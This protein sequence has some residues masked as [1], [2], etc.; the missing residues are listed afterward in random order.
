MTGSSLMLLAL[1]PMVPLT[2]QNHG[3]SG[4]KPGPVR[5]SARSPSLRPDPTSLEVTGSHGTTRRITLLRRTGDG[6]LVPLV[7]LAQA[8]GGTVARDSGWVV[9]DTPAGRFRFLPGTP[10]VDT[11][12]DVRGLPAPSMARGDTVFIP[13]AFVADVLADPDRQS[14]HWSP[15][16]AL[17]AAGRAPAPLVNRPARTTAGA[18]ARTR[19]P[20]GLRPGHHVTIDPGHG[21]TDPG[22]PGIFFPQG[23]QEKDVTLAIGLQVR[24]V[25]QKR[26]VT[27]TMTRSTDTLISLFDR[28]PDY[29]R[30]NCDLFVS[31]HV[32]SLEKRPGYTKMRGFETYFLSEA[33]TADAARVAKMENSAL[34]YDL[35]SKQTAPGGLNFI[36]KDLQTNEFLRE[37]ARAAALVQSHLAEVQSGVNG[38]VKQAEFA[39]LTT[40]RRPAILVEMGYGTN[41]QDARLLTTRTG[42]RAL[43]GAIADAVVGYLREVDRETGDSAAA[44]H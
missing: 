17:L 24:A 26:G 21:G 13:L 29:C 22:S 1:A 42:Q 11:G 3:T 30:I 18:E 2:A 44:G 28:A 35:P 19:Y 6:P 31:L 43:A 33:R 25:L 8:I 38:G 41:P 15:A 7:P 37:S 10:L 39:V 40:A 23:V 20:D 36:L 4:A 34:R 5:S 27:V 16:A 32:N 12:D 14:W 9:L